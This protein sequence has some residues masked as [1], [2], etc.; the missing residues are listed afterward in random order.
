MGLP[1]AVLSRAP[2][3][4]PATSDDRKA[5]VI[6]LALAAA[7]LVVRVLLAPGE[8]AGA[9]GYRPVSQD[10]PTRDSVAAVAS[11]LARP[12][13]RGERI[14]LDRAP[15][16]EL[17]R[18]P[19]VGPA[20]AA[21]IVAHREVHGPLGSLEALDGVPGVGPALLEAVRPHAAFSSGRA[22]SRQVQQ[23]AR[24]VT[25]NTA[26]AEDLAHLPAIGPTRARAIVE[27][28]RRRGPYARLE[29]LLRVPGIGAKTIERL[30]GRVR[31]P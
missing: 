6:M 15:A 8:P 5:A 17:A 20:L 23:Q 3:A 26:T 30:R 29:D 18:L 19:R 16:V 7:G 2:L 9:V 22:G 27:D 14:D 4:M 11:R 25:L 10:R 1:L 24:V 31:V 13:A 21:R 28:R 12:L